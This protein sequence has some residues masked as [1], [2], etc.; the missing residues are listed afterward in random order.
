V[1]ALSTRDLSSEPPDTET[2]RLAHRTLKKVG[3][4]IE[5]LRLNTAVSAMMI[6]ANHLNGLEKP[7]RAAVETLLVC[8]SP[9]APHLAEELWHQLGHPES[10][11]DVP[12]PAFDPALCEDDAHEIAVQ[13]SGKVRGRITVAKGASEDEVRA[14][15][16][17]DENVKKFLEGKTVRKF[18]YVPGRIANF[19]VG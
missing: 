16:S 10:I 18:I 9:F 17:A 5:G 14:L 12:W 7:P 1:H 2:L 8:L 15:A 4:D 11:A 19:I 6:M 3:E 13:V